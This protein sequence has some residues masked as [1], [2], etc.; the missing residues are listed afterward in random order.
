MGFVV[1]KVALGQVFSEYFC[2]PWQ[3]SFTK[4]SILKITRGKYNRP[5]VAD[6]P[7]GTSL[8]STPTTMRIK[9]FLHSFW[10]HRYFCIERKNLRVKK[11]S[12]LL[13]L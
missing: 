3:S 11:N 9:N 5:E 1:D 12:L 8:D 7:S 13:K 10:V 6:V 2:F 4:F